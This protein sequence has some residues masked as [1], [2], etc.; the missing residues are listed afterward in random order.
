MAASERI[1]PLLSMPSDSRIMPARSERRWSAAALRIALAM[2]VASVP[3]PAGDSSAIDS[4][5][6]AVQ[7]DSAKCSHSGWKCRWMAFS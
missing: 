7:S 2:F 1:S 6:S 5:D 3:S 4:S